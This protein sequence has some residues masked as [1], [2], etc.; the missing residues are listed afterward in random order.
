MRR[1]TIAGFVYCPRSH[2]VVPVA[3]AFACLENSSRSEAISE[4]DQLFRDRG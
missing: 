2:E 3:S 4:A 1:K